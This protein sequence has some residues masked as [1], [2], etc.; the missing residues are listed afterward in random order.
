MF[1]TFTFRRAV[2]RKRIGIIIAVP[3]LLVLAACGTNGQE[4]VTGVSATTTA[5]ATPTPVVTP[6]PKKAAA[7]DTTSFVIAGKKYTCQE[8]L[9]SNGAPCD[10]GQQTV[11]N[12]WGDNLN[13]FMS[14]SKLGASNENTP[15]DVVAELGLDACMAG[16]KSNDSTNFVDYAEH[17]YSNL[18]KAQIMSIWYAAAS[19]LCSND[20]TVN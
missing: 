5:E 3:L 10:D 2:M 12:Y 1:Y 17:T 13:A 20:S 16:V 18:G 9:N 11:F 4:D 15:Q 19:S 6:T 8:L 7:E 14:S